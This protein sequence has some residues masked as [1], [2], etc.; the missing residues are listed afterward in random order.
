MQSF[1]IEPLCRVGPVRIGMTREEARQ[2][3]RSGGASDL[4]S[5]KPNKDM[6]FDA[7]FQV[8]FDADGLV[9]LIETADSEH[10]AVTF[11][12]ELLHRLPAAEAVATLSRFAVGSNR[13]G[14]YTWVFPSLQIALWRAVVAE[15]SDP[16]RD[17]DD[18]CGTRFDAVAVGR[19]GYFRG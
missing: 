7:A 6:F 3:L 18:Q 9:E 15:K 14:G 16:E 10:F 4:R 19:A 13:D 12:G 17:L 11:H 2:A 1:D 8:T 5:R